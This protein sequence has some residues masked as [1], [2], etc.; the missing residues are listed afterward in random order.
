MIIVDGPLT[1][2]D[3]PLWIR[4]GPQ[5][6]ILMDGLQCSPLLVDYKVN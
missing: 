3:G 6:H 1:L 5:I 4:D 2:R